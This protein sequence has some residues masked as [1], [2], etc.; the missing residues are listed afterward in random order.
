MRG[1]NHRGNEEAREEDPVV[2][3]ARLKD[4]ISG[5]EAQVEA[6]EGGESRVVEDLKAQLEVVNERLAQGDTFDYYRV[7]AIVVAYMKNEIPAIVTASLEAALAAQAQKATAPKFGNQLQLTIITQKCA[8]GIGAWSPVGQGVKKVDIIKE[9]VRRIM[10][11]PIVLGNAAAQQPYRTANLARLG[12]D[13]I[14]ALATEL[15]AIPIP[16][17]KKG[18]SAAA[19]KTVKV[20]ASDARNSVQVSCM[21]G[22]TSCAC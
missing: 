9:V 2:V 6:L 17:S 11:R 16:V 19:T 3:I 1:N 15:V 18:V 13:K 20:I 8:E 21:S 7:A 22:H 10:E 12:E 5:L 4:A 14:T